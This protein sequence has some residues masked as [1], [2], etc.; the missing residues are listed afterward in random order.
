MRRSV[1]AHIVF[2]SDQWFHGVLQIAVS[3]MTPAQ[4][5][6]ELIVC[7]NGHRIDVEEIATAH[8]GRVHLVNSGPG[9]YTVDY[10]ATLT[11]QARPPTVTTSDRVT[12]L[13]PSRYAESDRLAAT[14][15]D[16]FYAIEGASDLL[17][18]V[19]SWVGSRLSYVPGSSG[20][21]S[22]AVD[23]L[24]AR[25]G[26]AGTTPISWSPCS[27]PWMSRPG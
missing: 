22:G 15:R 12:F 10:Q 2:E 24:L 5:D 20:P 11:G 21:T 6:E 17:A 1:A 16:E 14:A 27:G 13:R 3:A 26:C 8:D 4:L 18:A 19:S 7:R 25:Q 9:R 23:T